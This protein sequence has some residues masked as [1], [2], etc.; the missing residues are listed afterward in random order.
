LVDVDHPNVTPFYGIC[1]DPD[2][3]NSP[4]FITPYYPNGNVDVYLTNHPEADRLQLVRDTSPPV[5]SIL[6]VMAPSRSAK[7]PPA[8]PSCTE[9]KFPLSTGILK[10]W[11]FP[12]YA[13]LVPLANFIKPNI[14]VNDNGQACLTDFGHARALE[15][16]GFTSICGGS[17]R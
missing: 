9:P 14:L 13:I 7:S 15:C 3:P 10:R 1:Y 5:P 16:S 12:Y 17:C 6:D 4:C 2:W 8:F 11:L